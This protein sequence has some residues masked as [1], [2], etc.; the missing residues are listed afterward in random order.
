MQPVVTAMCQCKKTLKKDLQIF[1]L[2]LTSVVFLMSPN[3][4]MKK[5]V[6]ANWVMIH[7]FI[8]KQTDPSAVLQNP[9]LN[10]V[11]VIV[12]QKIWSPKAIFKKLHPKY[13]KSSKFLLVSS[14][15]SGLEPAHL[16]LQMWNQ[17]IM[18]SNWIIYEIYTL[19]ILFLKC[20]VCTSVPLFCT[21]LF[22]IFIFYYYKQK[23]HVQTF[24][25]TIAGHTSQT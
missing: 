12:F 1:F 2:R 25:L 24:R 23:D 8:Y 15:L 22:H 13:W 6:P 9:S 7:V 4:F 11:Q 18:I 20:L 17:A 19:I 14:S 5:R 21:D 16:A 10:F 3:V